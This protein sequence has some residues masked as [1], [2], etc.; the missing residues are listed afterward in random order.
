MTILDTTNWLLND[1]LLGLSN[2]ALRAYTNNLINGY[3][4]VE[5][6]NRTFV[7]TSGSGQ[8]RTAEYRYDCAIVPALTSLVQLPSRFTRSTVAHGKSVRPPQHLSWSGPQGQ[9]IHM[10]PCIDSVA[11]VYRSYNGDGSNNSWRYNALNFKFNIRH[12]YGS[13][14]R[15]YAFPNFNDAG[16]EMD[17]I[18]WRADNNLLH[19]S[20]LNWPITTTGAPATVVLGLNTQTGPFARRESF[21]NLTTKAY[22]VNHIPTHDNNFVNV[23]GSLQGRDGRYADGIPPQ[24]LIIGYRI[25][26]Q[27]APFTRYNVPRVSNPN[28]I[29]N[30][31]G[32]YSAGEELE[33]SPTDSLR[34]AGGP[35]TNLVQ[36]VPTAH[37]VNISDRVRL[38]GDVRVVFEDNEVLEV[39]PSDTIYIR[40]GTVPVDHDRSGI[41]NFEVTPMDG[42]RLTGHLVTDLARAYSVSPMDTIRLNPNVPLE[43]D[44]YAVMITDNINFDHDITTITSD[45][46]EVDILGVVSLQA[47]ILIVSD[48]EMVGNEI[49]LS[50]GGGF[51]PV[52][53]LRPRI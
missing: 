14:T 19:T 52:I 22:S 30:Q 50:G 9:H 42:I 10:S 40:S 48:G 16:Y 36:Y 34:I 47:R 32:I 31:G 37:Q 45:K 28:N 5:T 46:T 12:W 15:D 6:E 53:M 29:I 51:I 11:V 3:T 13:L 25:H 39:R 8:N 33:V 43:E 44:A 27:S 18:I 17:I 1:N 41:N 26:S 35:T 4:L 23:V 20:I 21:G 49:D 24:K 38:S 2:S 7:T